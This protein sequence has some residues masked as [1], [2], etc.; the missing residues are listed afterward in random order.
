MHGFLSHLPRCFVEILVCRNCPP[1]ASFRV[2]VS[3]FCERTL[4]AALGTVMRLVA[5]RVVFSGISLDSPFGLR[6]L[7]PFDLFRM[8]I[9]VKAWELS[10]PAGGW[11]VKGSGKA[12]FPGSAFS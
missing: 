3:G 4:G 2:T 11:N 5:V 8:K 6:D 9:F 10:W 12:G 1:R 7:S